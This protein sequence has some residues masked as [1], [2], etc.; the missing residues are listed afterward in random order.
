[1]CLA[2]TWLLPVTGRGLFLGWALP[3]PFYMSSYC[4]PSLRFSAT[5]RPSWGSADDRRIQTARYSPL[6]WRALLRLRR[7]RPSVPGAELGLVVE[8]RRVLWAYSYDD[9]EWNR[10]SLNCVFGMLVESV[11]ARGGAVYGA[12]FDGDAREFATCGSAHQRALMP[13]CA[14]STSRARPEGRSTAASPPTCAPPPVF[15]C[16][17]HITRPWRGRA[18]RLHQPSPV[19][20]PVSS[21]R[22]PRRVAAI[23]PRTRGKA[24]RTV[25]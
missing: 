19:G 20:Y 18:A 1:M 14:P 21:G 13:S 12:A 23:V 6:P 10:S 7:V 17:V 16:C 22:Q 8:S 24:I 9:G 3:T 15:F 2:G 25:M 11:L 5:A 4:F